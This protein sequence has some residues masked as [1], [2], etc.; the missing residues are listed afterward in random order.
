MAGFRAFQQ[1]PS[2]DDRTGQ[3]RRAGDRRA[4]R[5][6]FDPGFAATLVNQIAPP[7]TDYVTGYRAEPFTVRRGLIVNFR[8]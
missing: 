6:P 4:P 8:A 5:R 1:G 2:T 3:D 7:E